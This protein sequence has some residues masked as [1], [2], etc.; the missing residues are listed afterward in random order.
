M[1]TNSTDYAVKDISLAAFGRKELDIA[2]IEMPGLMSIRAEY[3]AA[4]PLKG[5][6]IA[7]SL[8]MTIQT[9]V[10]I[11]TL[12]ALGAEV[13]WVSCNIF[14]TQDH[15]AAAIAAAGIPVFAHKGESLEEYWDF[16]D[17][18]MDWPGSTPNMILD[19]GGDATMYIL[20]GAKAEKDIS[21]LD[22][23][24]NEEEEI[25]FD[26]IKRRLAKNPTFFSAIRASIRGVSEETTTGVMRLY[27]LHAKGELPFPAINVNDSVTKS[28][29][30]NKYGT[31]ES[32][33]DAIRRG[34]D[35]MLAGKVAIVCGFGDVGKGSAESLRGAGARVLV[36][37]VD[38]I[39]ALQAAMEGFEVV[40][41]EEAA[42]RADIVVTATGN[43]DVLMVDD[44]RKLKDMAI[45]CNIGHFDNEI[46]VL[47]LRNFKWTN[48]KPQVDLIE[49]PDGK[50]LILLSEGRLVNLGNATGHPSFVMSAS[51][52]NQTLAQIELWTNGENLEKKVHVLP[53]HLDEKVAEL[54]L[55]KL[56][57]KLTKLTPAQA[58]YIGV[59][60]DGPFK[61]GEYRY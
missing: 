52:A 56:G 16:T 2:E 20:T 5:A 49:K 38:P 55:A 6:R 14:S 51:F 27:Q 37:E 50:R 58:D 4:Q 21:I 1:T 43:R 32:L 19:D 36:T 48:V 54:H 17:R 44:M 60:T 23:P 13:R 57:A 47:G 26:T 12:V 45:V 59:S 31:R 9:A 41:L 33:V 7:G 30:D 42:E 28:K 22:K 34:T 15:A 25:F 39:C 35:V 46:D 29:F 10:L 53:K 24:G 40:T 8:H 61:S 3:A 18:M 11:E